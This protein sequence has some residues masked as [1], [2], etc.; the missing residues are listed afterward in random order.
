MQRY[1]RREILPAAGRDKFM[2]DVS[3]YT[4]DDVVGLARE[5]LGKVI[6]TAVNGRVTA[7][8]ISETEA[9]HQD[10][11]ACHAYNGKHTG[12]TRMLFREGGSAYVYL[13]YG[14]HHLF[15]IVTGPEGVAQ[16]VL[17]RG[18]LPFKGVDI[19]LERR[20]M[21]KMQRNLSA[22]PGTMS[23]ALGITTDLNGASLSGPYIWLEDAGIG[24]GSEDVLVSK[25]IGVDYAGRDAELPWRF[26]LA[27]EFNTIKTAM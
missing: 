18:I 4:T 3:F 15:N 20:Q 24:I 5:L 22:G 19:M 27:S 13:C 21:V 9:Y 6:Y 16:A 23:Q 17:V 2:L 11:K 12:R 1:Y 8:I 10:E 7:G 25:R 14:L 26:N